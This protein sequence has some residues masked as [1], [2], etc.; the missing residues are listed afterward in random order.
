[1]SSQGNRRDAPVT[2]LDGFCGSGAV[3][4][5]GGVS[6]AAASVLRGRWPG[7]I[8]GGNE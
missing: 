2:G 8:D 1:M 4:G 3:A 5:S 6:A 7:W